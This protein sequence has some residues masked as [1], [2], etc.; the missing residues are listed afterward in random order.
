MNGGFIPTVPADA[1]E[2]T[3][4]LPRPE[5]SRQTGGGFGVTMESD[6]L[7][8]DL[9]EGFRKRFPFLALPFQVVDRRTF[10][11]PDMEPNRLI[12]GDNLHVM[13]QLPDESIDLI[14]IDPPFF[15]GRHHRAVSGDRTEHRSFSD[16]WDDGLP[17]YLVWLNA[18]LFEM[19]RLLKK[20]GSLVVHCDH[21]ANH[22]IKVELDKIFGPGHF[23]NEIVWSYDSGGRSRNS[24]PR[25]HDVLLWFAKRRPFFSPE[26]VGIPRNV[27]PRCGRVL[28]KW[29]N[30]KKCADETG[31]TFRTIRSA[32]KVY[33]YYDDDRVCPPD[34]WLGINHLQQKDPE[35]IGYPTQK[36]EQLLERVI[37]GWCPEGG[38]VADFFCG[39]GTTP[40][41]AHRLGRRWIACDR[42]K[43]AVDVTR[44]RLTRLAVVPDD[45]SSPAPDFTLER[46]GVYETADVPPGELRAFILCAFG[47][48]RTESAG[49]I[50][51]FTGA[52]PLWL[53]D[54]DREAGVT[55][56]EVLAFADAVRKT[57]DAA[58][59]PMREGVMLAREFREDAVETAER[60]R[61]TAPDSP[62]CMRLDLVRVVSP[63]FGES[64]AHDGDGNFLTF[65]F[66]PIVDVEYALSGPRT[67]RF[68]AGG[69]SVRNPGAKI[70]AVAW[71]FDY[72]G[73]FSG[74]HRH[75]FVSGSEGEA[76]A[77]V[78]HT[79][80][81]SGKKRFACR[82]RDDMG[83]EGIHTGEIEVN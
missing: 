81:S 28:E 83:G 14:Y 50:D 65:V 41:A 48:D 16:V 11:N 32:G 43:E 53:G 60:L 51:G 24:Y 12:L 57:T 64:A 73:S 70:V 23:R 39:G 79:F 9:R 35:R 46:W 77:V 59:N 30:L 66:P 56:S 58:R 25:K 37:R 61:L 42:S 31:R 33:R 34:V 54:P 38:T 40:A 4:A 75:S 78:E 67:F 44:D 68:D 27:C 72:A 1:N 18:R 21:H 5:T 15:S 63:R 10:G 13:R 6:P 69:T 80:P 22:Y 17:G 52:T 19:R 74:A 49:G 71:D 8:W 20:T 47:A 45:E 26:A 29:N 55:A 36:P 82:V 2:R 3:N 62:G 7:G 76:A